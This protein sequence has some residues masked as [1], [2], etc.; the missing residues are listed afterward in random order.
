[1]KWHR[2]YLV[3]GLALALTAGVS[4]TAGE[5]SPTEVQ[6]EQS[7]DQPSQ[8]LGGLLAGD[9]LLGGVGDVV[10]GTVGTVVG[11]TDLL[12]CSPQ[13]YAVTTKAIGP[14]GGEIVVGSH[15]LR[16]PKGA[17]SKTVTIKAEQMSGS[18]NSLRFGPEGLQFAKSAQLTMSYRNCLVVL[19]PKKIAYTDERLNILELLRSKDLTGSKTVTGPVDHFSRYAVAY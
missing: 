6:I 18:V 12:T 16:I 1:M 17:L 5:G 7:A 19:F 10:E 3:V 11:L 14:N 4:C 9:G 2:S 15:V 13:Q 8:L